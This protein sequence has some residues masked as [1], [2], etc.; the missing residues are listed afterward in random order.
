MSQLTIFVLEDDPVIAESIR[1]NLM[2]LGYNVLEPASSKVEALHLLTSSK[3][4]FAILDINID[5]E[6]VGIEIGD[7]I[8]KNLNIP[9]IY[10]TG[11]SDKASIDSACKTH[12]QSYLI[13]PFT[14]H[15][16][17]SSIQIAI[18]NFSIKN[19]NSE[20][21]EEVNVLPGSV[22][23]KVGN[24]YIKV[25]I[26]EILYIKTDDKYIEIITSSNSYNVRANMESVLNILKEQK[27]A[28]VH[29][30]YAINLLHLKEVKGE[31]VTIN[32]LQIPIGRIY[33]DDL[34]KTIST[35]Q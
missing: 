34:L 11:N 35:F 24:K 16:L 9:F 15:E 23:I 10:L 33:R 26:V 32:D 13:K 19:P 21:S 27:F 12:P 14:L 18:S 29:R 2:E 25:L 28:R 7:Y 6:Q 8:N 22:F 5:G 4:D 31:F 20:F 30:S 17:Y 1:M 3:P